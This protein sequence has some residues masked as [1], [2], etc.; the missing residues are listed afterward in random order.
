[1]LG[2]RDDEAVA[3]N[4]RGLTNLTIAIAFGHFISFAPKAIVRGDEM[5]FSY[6]AAP[7][8]PASVKIHGDV[9]DP[10]CRRQKHDAPARD[11]LSVL[12]VLR[13]GYTG[14]GADN[15]RRLERG[16]LGTRSPGG[17]R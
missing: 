12:Q 8:G 15:Q 17:R 4:S 5:Y 13:F 14:S 11:D 16:R 10:E 7:S 6:R 9:F 1:M 3:C 2:C